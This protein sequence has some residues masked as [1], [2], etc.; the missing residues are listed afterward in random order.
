MAS[1]TFFV[2]T[3]PRGAGA[4]MNAAIFPRASS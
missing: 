4:P 3:K 1:V 2:N